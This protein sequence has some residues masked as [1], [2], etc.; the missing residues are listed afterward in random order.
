MTPRRQPPLDSTKNVTDPCVAVAV[1]EPCD[2]A[3][4][5]IRKVQI[6][7]DTITIDQIR[8]RRDDDRSAP[9]KRPGRMCPDRRRAI[10]E[11]KTA[12]EPVRVAGFDCTQ[13]IVERREVGDPHSHV[14]WHDRPDLVQHATKRIGPTDPNLSYLVDTFVAS[15]EVRMIIDCDVCD[16]RDTRACEDCIVTAMLGD[17]GILELADD[18]RTAIDAMSRVGLVSPLRLR[19]HPGEQRPAASS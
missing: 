6:T 5:T 14:G 2:G 10:H 15:K 19:I 1:G 9:W 8:N 11:A 4:T 16:M 13:S 7:V 18:E 3:T 17:Q 12:I